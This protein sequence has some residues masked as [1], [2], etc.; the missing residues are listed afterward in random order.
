VAA[1]VGSVQEGEKALAPIRRFGSPV[2]DAVQVQ[3]YTAVQQTFDGGMPAGV[4][5]LSRAHYLKGLPDQA[6]DLLLKYSRDLPGTSSSVY[7]EPLGGA[8]ARV[9]P[10][11]TAFPHRNAP[12]GLHVVGGWSDPAQDRA[13][14][15]WVTELHGA[16]EPYSTGGVYVNLLGVGEGKERV[17]AAYGEN[18]DRLREIK[19]RWD[20]DNLF[21]ANH[22]LG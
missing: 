13:L 1:Y 15:A 14:T 4:R 5:W 19:A 16:M 7:L 22:N 2:L 8:I 18:L 6:I 21:R 3:P 17:P 10:R 11:A 20:P 12:F 9:D